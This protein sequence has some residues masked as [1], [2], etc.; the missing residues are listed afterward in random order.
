MFVMMEIVRF[1][2]NAIQGT[3]TTASVVLLSSS[4]THE[5]NPIPFTTSLFGALFGI[6]S[7]SENMDSLNLKLCSTEDEEMKDVF[8]DKTTPK[9]SAQRDAP[10]VDKSEMDDNFESGLAQTTFDDDEGLE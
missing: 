1:E 5:N 6:N 4:T 3:I 9:F 2:A 7:K 8:N 10:I